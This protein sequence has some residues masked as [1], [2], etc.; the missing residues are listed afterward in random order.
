[1]LKALLNSTVFKDTSSPELFSFDDHVLPKSDIEEILTNKQNNLNLDSMFDKKSE[2]L[3]QMNDFTG[4]LAGWG[5]SNDIQNLIS[6]EKK[7]CF[8]GNVTVDKNITISNNFDRAITH[9]SLEAAIGYNHSD[10][11]VDWGVFSN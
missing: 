5:F 1:M 11:K 2:N 3:Q 4:S 8:K 9:R 10:T 6:Y 7:P